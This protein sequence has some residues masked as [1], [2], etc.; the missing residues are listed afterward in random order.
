MVNL[1]LWKLI[2]CYIL[3]CIFKHEQKNIVQFDAKI[4]Y[5]IVENIEDQFWL[6]LFYVIIITVILYKYIIVKRHHVNP[7]VKSTI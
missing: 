1:E 6:N 4:K 3:N 2:Y 5:T 7:H